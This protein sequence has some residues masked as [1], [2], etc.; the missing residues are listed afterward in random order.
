MWHSLTIEEVVKKLKTDDSRGLTSDEALSRFK[1]YGRN[2]I[3][4]KRK[5][6]AKILV[7]QFTN[8]LVIIL[9]WQQLYQ[10]F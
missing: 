6:P 3:A 10:C 8:S 4:V 5:S 9:L 2:E 1:S 7:R